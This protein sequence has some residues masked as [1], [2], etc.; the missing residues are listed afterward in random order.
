MQYVPGLRCVW[1]KLARKNRES[2][3]T[4]RTGS[5]RKILVSRTSEPIAHPAR[6]FCAGASTSRGPPRGPATP[7][8]IPTPREGVVRAIGEALEL[9]GTQ[10]AALADDPCRAEE[11]ET[12]PSFCRPR[13]A[14]P[15]GLGRPGCLP[16]LPQRAAGLPRLPARQ[17]CL[18][19]WPRGPCPSGPGPH[20]GAAACRCLSGA[21]AECRGS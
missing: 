20:L 10:L 4:L 17:A 13:L 14:A 3:R 9:E 8:H 7:A 15:A 21:A 16:C 6:K 19:A 11:A 18:P 1:G 5:A 12:G 2:A